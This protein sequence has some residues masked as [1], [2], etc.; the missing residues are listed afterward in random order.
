MPWRNNGNPIF[1]T[2]GALGHKI[3]SLGMVDAKW[4]TTAIYKAH[5][6]SLIFAVTLSSGSGIWD[7]GSRIWDLGSRIWG[8]GISDLGSGVRE[9]KVF[10][11]RY[12]E[13]QVPLSCE[14][15]DHSG[16]IYQ[17]E[18]APTRS[19]LMSTGD[20]KLRLH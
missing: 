4:K 3:M 9:V 10:D 6:N 11:N 15:P 17:V 19:V 5:T 1:M 20:R 18:W 7:L 14:N 12:Q 16:K 13:K 8:S 2:S